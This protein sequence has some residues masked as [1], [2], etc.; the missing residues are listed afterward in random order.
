M[1][2]FMVGAGEGGMTCAQP[3]GKTV[4]PVTHKRSEAGCRARRAG[5]SIAVDVAHEVHTAFLPWI[6]GFLA[7][8]SSWLLSASTT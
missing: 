1:E 4:P 8:T 2:D 3:V 7:V 5:A 6:E